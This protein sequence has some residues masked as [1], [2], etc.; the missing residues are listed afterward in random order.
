MGKADRLLSMCEAV[1][2]KRELVQ[3]IQQG[4]MSKPAP[5]DIEIIKRLKPGVYVPSRNQAGVYFQEMDLKSDELL[6]FPMKEHVEILTQIEK[7]WKKGKK[8]HDIGYLH[9]RGMLLEGPHRSGK[10]SAI[11]ILVEDTLAKDDV[12]FYTQSLGITINAIRMFKEVEPDRKLLCIM[13]DLDKL[14]QYGEHEILQL[15]DGNMSVDGV[16]YIATTN[17]LNRIPERVKSP[18]RFDYTI[19]VGHPP[20]E[21]RLIYLKHKL[22]G[23]E[24][25][26]QIKALS[27]RTDGFSFAHLRELIISHYLLDH[28]L[29]DA[30]KRLSSVASPDL[31]IAPESKFN[32]L[33]RKMPRLVEN[34]E[35]K[36]A[37]SK[38]DRLLNMCS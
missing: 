2:K 24:K 6:R 14:V 15:L 37:E 13:E 34:F 20:I 31:T 19:H 22:K 8:Y 23:I 17:Y 27:E 33:G 25:P 38:A 7:F 1:E 26:D 11:K 18:G 32:K 16:C 30:L 12:V 29:E 9:N 3:Y 4:S 36:P 21:G 10:S 5:E 35:G 28:K